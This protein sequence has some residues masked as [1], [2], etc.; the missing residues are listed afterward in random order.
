[1][2]DKKLLLMPGAKGRTTLQHDSGQSLTALFVMVALVLLIAC[3]N[4]ANLLLAQG[5][6][7]QRELAIRSAMG[8]SRGRML[9]QLLAA[10][11]LCALL[12]GM[13]GLVLGVWLMNLLTPFVASNLGVKGLSTSLDLEVLFFALSTTL[14]S[15]IFFGLIPAWRVTRSA[16][17]QTLKEQAAN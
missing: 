1:F 3:T 14:T 13:L 4:I 7:R 11:L 5:A 16:V 9:R 10:S 15:G 2:L 6:A 12:G 17:A 8:A